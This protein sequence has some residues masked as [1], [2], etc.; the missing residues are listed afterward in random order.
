ML[1]ST[2]PLSS[3]LRASLPHVMRISHVNYEIVSL[4][5]G[6]VKRHNA[7][8]SK[9]RRRR[10]EPASP[11][12]CTE[13]ERLAMRTKIASMKYLLCFIAAV[14][15]FGSSG[16]VASTLPLSAFEVCL[17]RLII[18]ALFMGLIFVV[19]RQQ[20]PRHI[21]RRQ[22]LFV[23]LSGA[24]LGLAMMTIFAAYR[25]LGVGLGAVLAAT[26]P[27]ITM[28]LSPLLFKEHLR[29]PVVV[30]FAIVVGGL[31][32]LNA[33]ALEGTLSVPG[34]LMG[35]AAAASTAGMVIFNKLARDITG[36]PCTTIQLAT[37]VAV[38][39]A[40]AAAGEGFAFIG[41]I[42]LSSWP[43]VIALGA[44]FTALAYFLYYRAIDQLPMQTVSVCAYAEPLTAVVLGALVLGEVMTPVQ[45]A[46]AC[47][48]IGGALLGEARVKLPAAQ[49]RRMRRAYVRLVRAQRRVLHHAA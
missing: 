5:R 3:L 6:F 9:G 23:A 20:L 16:I 48:I 46:G 49:R 25:L 30:G 45:L 36:I 37:A 38:A 34:I 35:L 40:V 22:Y 2:A 18:G 11:A 26:A 7:A 1:A 29:L 8:A 33:S 21:G 13:K 14:M 24:C 43:T 19:T 31:L 10:A 12:P 4:F 32:L 28:A 27:V 44:V 42:P 39:L 17:M 47:C 15:M 41:R